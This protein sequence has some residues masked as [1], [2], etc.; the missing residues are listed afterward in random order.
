MSKLLKVLPPLAIILVA[1]VAARIM[2]ANRPP[3]ERQAPRPPAPAVQVIEVERGEYQVHVLSRGVVEART[4]AT[5]LAQVS[6]EV[7][8]INPDFRDGGFFSAREVLVQIDPRDYQAAVTIAESDLVQAQQALAQEE[9]QS[10][11]AARDWQRLGGDDTPS[12]LTLRKPQLA[13]ARANLAA[14]EARLA[15]ARLNLQRTRISVPYD[16]RVLSQQVDIGQ[17]VGVGAVLGEVYAT[18]A[19]EIRLPLSNR[20]LAR[21]QVPEQYR[22]ESGEPQGPGVR[23]SALVGDQLHSWDGRIVRSEGA[24]DSG[25]RQTFVVARVDAPYA[26]QDDGRPPLKVGQYVEASIEGEVLEDVFVIPSSAVRG[27]V[28]AYVVG[29]DNRLSERRLDVVWRGENNVVAAAGLKSGERVITTVPSGAAEG[30]L[31]R[32]PAETPKQEKTAEPTEAMES[33]AS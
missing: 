9:A 1:V 20:Q 10:A 31:V 3:A 29:E 19:V 30:M 13:T 5:L 15:Q 22:G 23:L 17:V 28:L 21:L 18:D 8:K 12:E 14:A 11:Q 24:I 4:R 16:G 27:D 32:L 26:R 25:S 33:P 7:V 6:G 2:I